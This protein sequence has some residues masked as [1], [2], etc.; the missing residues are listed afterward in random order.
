MTR[1]C[2][3]HNWQTL[4]SIEEICDAMIAT[5]TAAAFCRSEQEFLLC[6]LQAAGDLLEVGCC[7]F[8]A[9]PGS[10]FDHVGTVRVNQRAGNELQI[11]DSLPPAFADH[12]RRQSGRIIVSRDWDALS[13]IFPNFDF[14][15]SA[16]LWVSVENEDR[17]FGTLAFF[18]HSSRRFERTQ[19]KIADLAANV[20]KLGLESQVGR[21]AMRSNEAAAYHEF[22][23]LVGGIARD[24][25]NPLAA[26]FG[27]IELLKAE[28]IEGRST[29]LVARMEEQI[30]K[31]RRVI[32]A[33]STVSGQPRFARVEAPITVPKTELTRPRP[34]LVKRP[35]TA[36]P[37][38]VWQPNP[39]QSAGSSRILL[40]QRSEAV[41]EFERS[42]LSALG[43]EIVPAL[44]AHDAIDLLRTKKMDAVI[45]DEELEENFS[46]KRMV[47]WIR[48]HRPELADHMLLTVSR[49]PNAETREILESAMVPHVTKPLEVLELF[50]RAQQVL[51]ASR[52]PQMLQ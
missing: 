37:A 25:I 23:K 15:N 41:L 10:P 52:N 6:A 50:S 31:A 8:Y 18:D 43:A 11:P 13:T 29:H 44:T 45:L 24:L 47:S 16:S 2:L 7:A 14:A 19:Q 30:E 12:V 21:D 22:S 38:P 27:Y 5:G 42:V 39:S 46:S 20:I 40:I 35:E 48:E 9:T 51:Q 17:I 28:S 3:F 49:K 32:A 26:I 1:S 4:Y 36:E 33:L 34:L